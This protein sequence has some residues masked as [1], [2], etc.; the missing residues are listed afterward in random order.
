MNVTVE[1]DHFWPRVDELLCAFTRQDD[2]TVQFAAV[3]ANATH[4]VCQVDMSSL[5]AMSDGA[6]SIVNVRIASVSDGWASNAVQL[7]LRG[8]LN[9]L[10]SVCC[11]PYSVC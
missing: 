9:G 10:L 7:S 5:R 1:G 11:L 3:T 6:V 8:T 4:V 2:S